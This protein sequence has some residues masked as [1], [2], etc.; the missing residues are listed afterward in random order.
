M[1]FAGDGSEAWHVRVDLIAPDGDGS[2]VARVAEAFR[3]VLGGRREDRGA[4]VDQ[5]IGVEGQPVIG[6]TFWVHADDIGTAATTALTTARGA[7]ASVDVGPEYYAV[8]LVPR[9]AIVVPEGEHEIWM[10]D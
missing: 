1:L 3:H 4:G 2:R 10:P 9:K 8:T 5:G 7:S 6:L